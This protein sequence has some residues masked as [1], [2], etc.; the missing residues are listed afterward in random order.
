MTQDLIGAVSDF[1]HE[2]NTEY[3]LTHI[4]SS[5]DLHK[6][7]D[8][9]YLMETPQRKSMPKLGPCQFVS[10]ALHEHLK[11][12]GIKSTFLAQ[13]I[14]EHGHNFL[15][16]LVEAQDN[17]IDLLSNIYISDTPE[18]V[19]Q[20]KCV[21]EIKGYHTFAPEQFPEDYN[22]FWKSEFTK[23]WAGRYTEQNLLDLYS[24]MPNK[25]P[26]KPNYKLIIA[27]TLNQ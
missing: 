27:N 9:T 3:T 5:D 4:H 2:L 15:H 13:K 12:K 17:Y 14:V 22:N 6:L 7:I 24:R 20:K 1:V 8:G 11:D 21:T 26:T 25:E 19:L 16:F 23:D 10:Y 18:L